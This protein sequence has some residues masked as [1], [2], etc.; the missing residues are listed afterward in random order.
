MGGYRIYLILAVALVGLAAVP[1]SAQISN[2]R[3]AEQQ[4]QTEALQ[5]ALRRIG[6]RPNDAGALADAGI[7]ALELGDV[8]AAIGFLAKAEQYAPSDGR[9]KVGLGRALLLSE[10][11]AGA[12]RYFDQAV[13][14]GA[15]E[16]DIAVERGLALDLIGNP[17]A[18]QRE[19]ARALSYDRSDELVHYY[20]VS[21]AISGKLKDADARLDPLLRKQDPTAWRSRAMIYAMNDE[22]GEARAIA[23]ATMQ[24]ALARAILPFFKAMPRLTPAQKA[25]AV[26]LGHFPASENIGVDVASVRAASEL[27]VRGGTGADAGLIPVGKPLGGD[28]RKPRVL[29]MPDKRQRRRPGRGSEEAG[30]SRDVG[31]SRIGPIASS[32]NNV[33]AAPAEPPPAEAPASPP[34]P[35]P[36]PAEKAV[37][38][39]QPVTTQSKPAASS[40]ITPSPSAPAP[41]FSAPV[42]PVSQRAS[43]SDVVIVASVDN[44]PGTESAPVGEDIWTAAPVQPSRPPDVG[45]SPTPPASPTPKKTQEIQIDAGKTSAPTNLIDFDLANTKATSAAAMGN[46]EETESASSSLADLIADVAIPENERRRTVAAVDLSKIEA[47]KPAPKPAPEPAPPAP[48]A[49]PDHPKRYWVQIATGSDLSALR[50]DYRRMARKHG[51]L[52]DGHSGW[53]SRWGQTR[54][55]V[56][57]PFD[58]LRAAKSFEADFRADDG[59]GFAWVSDEGTVVEPLPKK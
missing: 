53:T 35:A 2:L 37:A 22:Q 26:H 49:K 28:V 24:P 17:E 42:V 41:G 4:Q 13:R 7:A 9:V 50:F 48:P 45:P 54:R 44:N 59:D 29:A 51:T 16:R 36:A 19:Y 5:S 12:L 20:A 34:A 14:N 31:S 56:V 1:A 33:T 46:G 3:T 8:N 27:A 11:P 21:L 38:A 10:N 57:G 47:A 52:F 23:E 40:A 43:S 30:K 55:L 15:A 39:A 32:R 25:A 18:A 6:Q 58:N